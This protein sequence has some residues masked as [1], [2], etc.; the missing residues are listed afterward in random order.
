M[1]H[2]KT[3]IGA[4]LS[5]L[6]KALTGTGI[7]AQLT[8]L[9]PSSNVIPPAIL[10]ACWW[11]TLIGVV[12]GVVG[13]ALTGWFT[14]DASTVNNVAAEVDRVNQQGPS[15]NAQPAAENKTPSQL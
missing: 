5:S 6:G 7:L 11:I 14:A 13:T 9:M 2:S 10:T 1:N 8:Q 4:L 15:V 3:T 12:L